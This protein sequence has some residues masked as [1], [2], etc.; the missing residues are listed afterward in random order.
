MPHFF[1]IH[2]EFILSQNLPSLLTNQELLLSPVWGVSP[3]QV[4]M[5]VHVRGMCGECHLCRY[6][7]VYMCGECVGS[8]TCAGTYVCDLQ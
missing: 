4:R 2:F 8:V 7:C 6:V 1:T 3:A 5:C